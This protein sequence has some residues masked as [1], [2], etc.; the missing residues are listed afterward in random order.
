MRTTMVL[1]FLVLGAVGCGDS[2]ASSC[3]D[4]NGTICNNCSASGDCNITCGAEEQE[5]CVGLE[6]FGGDNPDDLRCAYC[7]GG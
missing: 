3:A 2:E 7:D 6:F 5:T 1:S 4:V